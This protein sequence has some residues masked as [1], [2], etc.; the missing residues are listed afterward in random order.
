MASFCLSA[1]RS[2]GLTYPSGIPSL[3]GSILLAELKKKVD[4]CL[5]GLFERAYSDAPETVGLLDGEHLVALGHLDILPVF[6]QKDLLLQD[7]GIG[8]LGQRAPRGYR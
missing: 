2:S 6:L 8:L 1:S 3:S 5:D 7:K 4:P